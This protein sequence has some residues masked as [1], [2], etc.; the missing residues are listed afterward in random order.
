MSVRAFFFFLKALDKDMTSM[1]PEAYEKPQVRVEAL[2][3]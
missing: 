1:A 3:R 2:L